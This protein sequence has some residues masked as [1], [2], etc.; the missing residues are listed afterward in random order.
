MRYMNNV[1]MGP[2]PQAPMEGV[3]DAFL[4][5]HHDYFSVTNCRHAGNII[6][7]GN[8]HRLQISLWN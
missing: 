8:L 7:F 2:W 4:C 3:I 5:E 1:V 6:V